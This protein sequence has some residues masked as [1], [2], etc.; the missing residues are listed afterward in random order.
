MLILGVLHTSGSTMTI[1]ALGAAFQ[2]LVC[3]LT[4]LSTRSWRQPLGPSV[5]TLYLIAL[6]WLWMSQLDFQDWYTHLSESVL[7]IVP[8]CFFAYETLNSSGAVA[9]RRAC[10]LAQRLAQRKDW[11]AD[12]AACRNLPE[13]KAFREALH[14]DA[15]P[16]LGLLPAGPLP[17]RVA[18][19]AALEFYRNWRPG[20][21]QFVM[22]L[23]RRSTE[24]AIR[25]G[26]VAALANVDDRLILEEL[27]EFLQDA[28]PGVRRA[29]VEALLW[30]TER[31]WSWIRQA[32]RHHLSNSAHDQD[33]P[34]NCEGLALP[35]EAVADLHAWSTEKGILA[36]RSAQTLRVYYTRLLCEKSAERTVE[37]LKELVADPRS[38]ATLRIELAQLL[39]A[40]DRWDDA[41]TKKLLDPGNPAPLRLLAI[42]AILAAGP[43]GPALNALYQIARLPNREIALASA[44]VAQRRLGVDLGLP[45]GKPLPALHTRQAA[46]VTRRVMLWA[47]QQE[48]VAV[49]P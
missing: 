1:L 5:I 15:S 35:K 17:V 3:C 36:V 13:V 24:P 12:L 49:N 4:F 11:P 21:V 29:A 46:E 18:A 45:F 27:A 42:D 8:L 34:L 25:A 30:N 9:R 38:P 32:V 44:E 6:G 19:L 48:Q 10:I 37:A 23:A 31:R 39:H 16:A 33:G 40:Q 41:L 26:A 2:L 14:H 20:Q 22:K 28:S 47:E 43:D 7:L